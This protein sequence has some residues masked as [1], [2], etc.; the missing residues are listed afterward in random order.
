LLI[1]DNPLKT[2]VGKSFDLAWVT[3]AAPKSVKSRRGIALSSIVIEA[4]K[5]RRIIQIE[6]QLLAGGHW[7][8]K[9]NLVFTNLRGKPTNPPNFSSRN[10]QQLLKKSGIRK[11]RFH[12]LRH[13]TANLLLSKCSS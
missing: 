6:D 5:R 9:E 8:N 2:I 10:F 1:A 11:I 4:I 13:S 12:D 3:I 7:S